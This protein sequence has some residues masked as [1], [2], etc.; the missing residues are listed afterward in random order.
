MRLWRNW[1][2]RTV[3]VRVGN[4]EGSNP[5][6]R[7]KNYQKAVQGLFCFNGFAITNNIY[8]FV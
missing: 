6:S 1:Q 5:F 2:T 8:S 4:H 3:Q 7:T